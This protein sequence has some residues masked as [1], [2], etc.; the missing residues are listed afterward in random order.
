MIDDRDLK[1]AHPLLEEL[2]GW[3]VTEGNQWK[4]EEFDLIDILA[5]LRLYNNKILIEQWVGIDDKN[6]DENILQV[7]YFS[8]P[9]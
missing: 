6:S 8:K 9:R 4:E 1:P 7:T 5:R 2:G 3:P